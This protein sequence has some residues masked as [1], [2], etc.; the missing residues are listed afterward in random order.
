MKKLLYTVLG[1][2]TIV[3][4]AYLLLKSAE[5]AEEEAAHENLMRETESLLAEVE[6]ED[7]SSI[8]MALES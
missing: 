5:S 3:G 8:G 4:A 6:I 1:A 7:E 2:S